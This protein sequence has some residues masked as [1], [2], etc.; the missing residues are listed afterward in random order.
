M[1]VVGTVTVDCCL[2]PLLSSVASFLPLSRRDVVSSQS[3][4]DDASHAVSLYPQACSETPLDRKD[5]V[6]TTLPSELLIVVFHISV[7]LSPYSALYF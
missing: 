3:N 1:P 5:H 4:N 2:V 6:S 7:S